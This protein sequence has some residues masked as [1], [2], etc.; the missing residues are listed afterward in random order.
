MYDTWRTCAKSLQS[1]NYICILCAHQEP[2][3]FATSVMENI[4]YG[5]P[6]ATDEDVYAAAQQVGKSDYA[7]SATVWHVTLS[8]MIP[9]FHL[10]GGRRQDVDP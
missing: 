8:G 1:V 4:R 2:V 7:Q 3:L 10:L 9:G 6:D 5:R